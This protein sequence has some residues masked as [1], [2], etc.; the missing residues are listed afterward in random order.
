MVVA[1]VSSKGQI[2]LPAKM[3]KKL[4]IRASDRVVLETRD[5]SIVIKLSKDFFEY[6]NFLGKALSVN[7]ERKRMARGVS[8]HTKGAGR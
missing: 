7:E 5:D 6:Q 2:T 8:A 1:T 3:R 4:G